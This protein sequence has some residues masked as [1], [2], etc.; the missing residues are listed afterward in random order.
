[1]KGINP[2]IRNLNYSFQTHSHFIPPSLNK[3]STIFHSWIE[4]SSPVTEQVEKQEFK[5]EEAAKDVN[6]NEEL[7][8]N[9]I[10][11]PPEEVITEPAL[12]EAVPVTEA[13]GETAAE[14]GCP[15]WRKPPAR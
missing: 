11:P 2:S 14:N 6:V 5:G 9:P 7:L 13:A 12:E 4:V 15:V 3:T 1:M 10:T 8:E